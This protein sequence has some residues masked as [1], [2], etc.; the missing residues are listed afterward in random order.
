MRAH[1]VKD[2]KVVN[3]IEVESLDL[4]PGLISGENGGG[5]GDSWDGKKFITPP[6]V[7]DPAVIRAE[8]AAA[9]L[10]IIRALIE[11]DKARIAAHAAEQAQRRAKLK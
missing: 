5:I 2:G 3:T 4:M 7:I 10:K 11:G 8:M 9:D 1:I 6:P